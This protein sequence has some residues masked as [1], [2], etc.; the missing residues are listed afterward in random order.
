M[1]RQAAASPRALV[2]TMYPE[3]SDTYL[4]QDRP[5]STTPSGQGEVS[6]PAVESTTSGG[7]D[8]DHLEQKDLLRRQALTL[9]GTA[10]LIALLVATFRIYERK[11]NFSP[12]QKTSLN[13]IILA[14]GLAFS[15]NFLVS[16]QLIQ[17]KAASLCIE[18]RGRGLTIEQQAFK[19]SARAFRVRWAHSY[20]KADSLGYL[21][22]FSAVLLLGWKSIPDKRWL[23][24]L[25]CSAWVSYVVFLPRLLRYWRPY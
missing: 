13:A 9:I 3:G 24:V 17:R 10:I 15:L 25:A 22:N 2:R 12:S 16:S 20:G 23:R 4:L 19:T 8:G 7:H 1:G 14:L 18:N 21:E 5:T 6:Q 11:G